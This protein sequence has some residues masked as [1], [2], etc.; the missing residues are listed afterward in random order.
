M[1]ELEYSQTPLYVQLYTEL[2]RAIDE[3]DLKPGERFPTES[4]LVEKYH[5]S[6]TT[7]RN[8]LKEMTKESYLVRYRGR[9]SYVSQ[10]K[11]SRPLSAKVNSFSE[12]CREINCKPGARVM[13][14]QLEDALPEDLEELD[15]PEGS[16]VVA[17]ER[18]RLADNVPVSLEI[19][20]FTESFD[21]LLFGD[22]NNCSMYELI[23]KK[24]GISFVSSRKVIEM[25]F[26]NYETAK[27]LCIPN[28][29]PLISI[30]SVVSCT[31]GKKAHRSLQLIVGDKFKFII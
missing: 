24:C 20:R 21:F 22:L 12:I 10:K 16:K 9:G 18:V 11:M 2:K 3:G 6:R 26:A 5:V 30:A 17:I 8:A 29:Y 31:N 19:A 7:V 23:Q 13:K 14:C 27:Y 1:P 28:D 4:E 15:L 25:V